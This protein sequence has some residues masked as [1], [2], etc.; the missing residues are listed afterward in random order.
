MG[1]NL[2]E[3]R[4]LTAPLLNVVAQSDVIVP[5]N[6]S[7]A[8]MKLVGSQDKANVVF[9]TGHLGIAIGPGACFIV[10]ERS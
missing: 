3:L 4:N 2:V 7:L 8:L 10:A 5:P 9:P 6:S 1:G